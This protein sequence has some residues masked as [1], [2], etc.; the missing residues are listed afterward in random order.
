[1]YTDETSVRKQIPPAQQHICPNALTV[2]LSMIHYTHSQRF[3]HTGRVER[4]FH[5]F[6]QNKKVLGVRIELPIS[7]KSR[8]GPD[9]V[10][11]RVLVQSRPAQ[12]PHASQLIFLRLSPACHTISGRFWI[13]R[14]LLRMIAAWA[15]REPL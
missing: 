2:T 12:G 3:T 9:S 8:Y 10:E 14:S 11:G 6:G 7:E 1:M 4:L 15:G 13:L 5:E